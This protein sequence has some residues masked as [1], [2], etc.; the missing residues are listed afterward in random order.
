MRAAAW[1]VLTAAAAGVAGRAWG[2]DAGAPLAAGRT[3]SFQ[4]TPDVGSP[5]ERAVPGRAYALAVGMDRE[6]R[7]S[8]AASL[9][10]Q[11]IGEW[12]A[13]MRLRPSH[14][15][16]QALQKAERERQRS[17]LL[18]SM[19]PGRGHADFP[20]TRMSALDEGRLYRTKLMV[21]RAFTGAVPA[22]LYARTRAALEQALRARAAATAAPGAAASPGG[23][24]SSS[25]AEIQLLLCATHA[26]AG[27]ARAARLARA[28]VSEA[29]REQPGNALA[30]AVCAAALGEDAQALARL[31]M[32]VLRPPPHHVDAYTLR[33]LYV[34]NDW[35]RLRGEQRFETLFR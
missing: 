3:T 6:Q 13:A 17:Q 32:F 4:A 15:L 7:W 26:A 29:D 1:L 23:T 24:G 12:S 2:D 28:G 21:V 5:V 22:S 25:D 34:A 9:Y 11:A 31:E 27:D 35:D 19:Q 20:A 18:A 14:A 10:Q 16:E 8:E 30:M 33:D